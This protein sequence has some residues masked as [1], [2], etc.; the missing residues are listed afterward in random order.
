MKLPIINAKH[1][2]P[3]NNY[4]KVKKRRN[5]YKRN[6]I[7]QN[8]QWNRVY[9]DLINYTATLE[10]RLAFSNVHKILTCIQIQR[11]YTIFSETDV[12]LISVI[13]LIKKI[14]VG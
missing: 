13:G 10:C 11:L 12:M 3:V 2:K 7:K 14:F 5:N 1:S 8:S 9:I 6:N 4:V